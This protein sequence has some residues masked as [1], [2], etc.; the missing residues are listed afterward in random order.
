M[1]LE[2][3]TPLSE[4]FEQ[5]SARRGHGSFKN[6]KR[7]SVRRAIP[8]IALVCSALLFGASTPAMASD[9][10]RVECGVGGVPGPWV[11]LYRDINFGGEQ[12]CF[13]GLGKIELINY[14]F[15]FEA[16]SINIGADGFFVDGLGKQ[17]GF[18]PGMRVADLRA[19]GWNDRIRN[20][21]ITG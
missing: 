21:V 2:N 5:S 17:L 16:S 6:A 1:T 10:I 15:E 4:L 11:A 8:I 12:I 19:M 18:Y 7:V 13:V 14:G 9:P 3:T 20:F